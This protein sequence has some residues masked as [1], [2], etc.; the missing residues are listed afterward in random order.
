MNWTLRRHPR[1]NE[2]S[3]HGQFLSPIGM[4]VPP[5]PVRAALSLVGGSQVKCRHATILIRASAARERR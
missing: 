4:L 5:F 3:G 1:R 2:L